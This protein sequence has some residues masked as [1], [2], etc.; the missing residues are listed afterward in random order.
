MNHRKTT[1]ICLSKKEL[2][3][4]KRERKKLNVS[5]ST[6]LDL[7]YMSIKNINLNKNATKKERVTISLSKEVY[8]QLKK[9]AEKNNISVSEAISFYLK[10]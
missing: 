10:Q 9:L 4:F 5:I 3:K 6:Y 1:S 7:I 2:H 8:T